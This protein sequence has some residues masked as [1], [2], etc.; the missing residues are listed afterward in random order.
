MSKARLII[1]AVILEGRSQ[2]EVA[3]AYGVN[4][5]WVSRL[6]ARYRTEGETAFQARSRRPKTNPT[7]ISPVTI[8]LIV[9]LRHDLTAAG[10][11]AG[12]DTIAWHLRHHHAIAVSPAT[13][14]RYLTRTGLVTPAPKKRPRSSY[15][16]FQAAMPNETWQADFTHY[17]L[18]HPDA[19]PGP[20][21]EILSWLDDCSR[22][23]L[24]VTAH[25]RVTG[26]IVLASFRA[27]ITHHGTPAATLTDN[28]MVFTT[29]LSG[30]KGGRNGLESELRRRNVTQ[31]NSRPNHPR[32]CGKV[33]RFQQTLKRWLTAQP[34]QPGTVAE[35]QALPGPAGRIHRRVQPPP[36]APVTAAPGH[37]SDRLHHHPQSG[38]D[39]QP[40]PQHPHPR[41]TRPHRHQRQRHPASW[42]AAAPHRDR[43]NPRPNRR[44]PARQ[45]PRHPHHQR[46]HR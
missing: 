25:A 33:E 13:I 41:P 29:R 26:P 4:Q 38:P 16:R 36:A 7:A 27:A 44:H 8:A 43:P 30:G 31:K 42:R 20:D 9:Q 2:R 19:S 34:V 37:P 5:S 39:Q 35:L 23:A 46:G 18:T 3:R 10:L 22:Y 45:R 12:P 17:R 40:R 1:T 24:G 21:T 15:Q 6:V 11:D 14:S 28:G 32:T